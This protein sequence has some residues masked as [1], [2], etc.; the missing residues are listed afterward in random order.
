MKL[1]LNL[2]I[3][4]LLF[5]CKSIETTTNN[6]RYS[7][8]IEY[9]KNEPIKAK[10]LIF[11]NYKF[12]SGYSNTAASLGM[13]FKG[14]QINFWS[15]IEGAF[16][17]IMK[18]NLNNDQIADF[19]IENIFEDGSTLYA[20]VSKDVTEFEKKKITDN[21]YGTYCIEGS[22]TLYNLLPFLIKDID[23]NMTNEV[24]VN[25]AKINNQIIAISCTDTFYIDRNKY[26]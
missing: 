4:L 17:T 22:D 26:D 8:G 23:N 24:I 3:L 19:L 9:G 12:I 20:L 2:L 14:K 6:S 21:Y 18:V 25:L 11:G 13:Y 15:S 16:D 5:S 7:S 1:E 10:E